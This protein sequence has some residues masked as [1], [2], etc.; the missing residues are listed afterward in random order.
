MSVPTVYSS[1]LRAST[2]PSPQ[3]QAINLEPLFAPRRVAV[4][5]ASVAAPG[6]SRVLLASAGS[7]V[8]PGPLP[9]LL[10]SRSVLRARADT[11]PKP[12]AAPPV[13]A[14]PAAPLR[15]PLPPP[16]APPSLKLP[17]AALC[18]G[19]QVAAQAAAQAAAAHAA[20]TSRRR[21]HGADRGHC[22][23]VAGHLCTASPA[24]SATP[25]SCGSTAS[26]GSTPGNVSG[27]S[28]RTATPTNEDPL[29]SAQPCRPRGEIEPRGLRCQAGASLLSGGWATPQVPPPQGVGVRFRVV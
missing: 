22:A 14:A 4:A 9:V 20:V 13:L 6:P 28:S 21:R 8:T 15:L 25:D 27:R 18:G 1:F 11:L 10:G 3:A 26:G 7:P 17:E 5:A 24:G 29:L 23:V 12:P 16:L 19:A 2:T